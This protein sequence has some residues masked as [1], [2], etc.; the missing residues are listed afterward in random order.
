MRGFSLLEIIV[1]IVVAGILATLAVTQYSPVRERAIAREAIAA[2]RLI[3]AAE[4][5]YRL[6]LGGYYPPLAASPKTDIAQINRDLQLLINENNWDYNITRTSADTFTASAAR[7]SGC[8]YTIDQAGNE[9]TG[10]GC[11]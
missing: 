8:L 11:P 9:V 10:A 4:R 7:P 3:A 1:V 5:I 6:E 2:L